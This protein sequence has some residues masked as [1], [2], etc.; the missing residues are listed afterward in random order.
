MC[1][2]LFLCFIV[3][4]V[5]VFLFSSIVDSVVCR[6]FLL[7][8]CSSVSSSRCSLWVLLVVYR[9][10]LLVVMVGILIVFSV[11]WMCVV[12]LCECIS[13]VMLLGCIGCLCSSVWF[14]CVWMRM[15]WI[16]VM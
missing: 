3:L 9:F 8:G 10:C 5:C 2:D 7:V 11:C 16:L 15:W 12:F 6:C 13:M 4:M 14:C 1:C